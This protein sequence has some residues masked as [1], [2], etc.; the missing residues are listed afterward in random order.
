[1]NIT[2]DIIY[3]GVDDADIEL[4]ENQYAMQNGVT[5]NSYVILE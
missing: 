3:I 2:S 1:M 5:Y 4:F